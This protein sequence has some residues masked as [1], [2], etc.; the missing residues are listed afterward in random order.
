MG[1][2]IAGF[3]VV[4]WDR[5]GYLRSAYETVEGGQFNRLSFQLWYQTPS[6]AI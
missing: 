1:D 6:T 5:E 3:A 2:D 4:V